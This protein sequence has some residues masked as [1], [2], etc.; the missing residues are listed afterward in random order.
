MIDQWD[1]KAAAGETSFGSLFDDRRTWAQ[2]GGY[3]Q[4]EDKAKRRRGR[5]RRPPTP[6]TTTSSRR[7]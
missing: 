3:Q 2:F 4:A 5:A 6:A 7:C 1:A